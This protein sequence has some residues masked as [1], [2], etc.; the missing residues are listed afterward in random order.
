[1]VDVCDTGHDH[2]RE[3]VKEPANDWIDGRV[4]NLVNVG[5]AELCIASLPPDQIPQHDHGRECQRQG[6]SPVDERIAKEEVLSDVIFPR[7]HSKTDI[8]NRPLPE[9][10][11]KII[12]LVWIW[13]QSV[14]GCRHC[15][16]EMYKVSKERRLICSRIGSRY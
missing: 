14:V 3:V 10:G 1:M 7:T 8:Q 5:L 6:R 9:L 4:V 2:K 15:H 13:H 16:V 11:C 12:L